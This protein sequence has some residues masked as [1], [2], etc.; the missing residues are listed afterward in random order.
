MTREY[1][2]TRI[3]IKN[4]EEIKNQLID[5]LM[6]FDKERRTYQQDVYFYID[7][8]TNNAELDI[9]ANV[10]G[11][12]WKEDDHITIYRDQAHCNDELTFF[13]GSDSIENYAEYA[14]I[15]KERLIAEVAEANDCDIDDVD[16]GDVY[17]YMLGNDKYLEKLENLYCEAIDEQMAEYKEK[18]EQILEDSD[19]YAA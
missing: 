12:S 1:E 2:N 15:T 19:I 11:N 16:T 4:Y 17:Q 13:F 9:F 6:A 7:E 10:G 14:E 5:M 3:E 18:A 8:E